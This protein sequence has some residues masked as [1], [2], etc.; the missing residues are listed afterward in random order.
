MLLTKT[1]FIK[2]HGSSKQHYINKGYKFTKFGDE[3]EVKVEDLQ[4]GNHSV[5]QVL[6]DYCLETTMNK[7]YR[8]YIIQRENS[9]IHK[10]CCKK[11]SILKVKEGNLLIYGTEFVFQ[12]PEVREKRK[13]TMI[14]LYGAEEPSSSKILQ[15]KRLKIVQ[16]KYG[17]DNVFQLDDI[18]QKRKITMEEKYGNE[19]ALLVEEFNNKRI[20]TMMDNFGVI[21]P[22]QNPIIKE[23]I[24]STNINRYGFKCVLE[25]EVVKEKAVKTMNDRYGVDN[26]ASTEEHQILKKATMMRKYGV[27]FSMQNPIIL[28]KSRLTMFK[29]GTAPCSTQQRYLYNLLGGELNYPISKCSVDVAFPEDKIYLEYDGGGHDLQVQFGNMTLEDFN[30]KEMK[31]YYFLKNKG[32]KQIIICSD[33]DYIP[34]DNVLLDIISYAMDFLKE[35]HSWIKFDINNAKIINSQ[36]EIR[37]NFGK[38]RKISKNDLID[39]EC[40]MEEGGI[41]LNYEQISRIGSK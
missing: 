29:N 38:L 13:T 37:V 22:I 27:E 9:V 31:R 4:N 11:C 2:W 35:G 8:T 6:C 23:K 21:Y 30:N 36:G 1:V 41:V 33:N 5:V 25:N 28:A 14:N 39:I 32:W 40:E 12:L 24:E 16:E 20:K 15:D 17:V 18:K 34:K 19:H 3:F 26:F 7:E 10:D